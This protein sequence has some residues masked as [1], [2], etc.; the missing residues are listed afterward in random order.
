MIPIH[1]AELAY[2]LITST[3]TTWIYIICHN[4]HD[5]DGLYQPPKGTLYSNMVMNNATTIARI[6]TSYGMWLLN[7][8]IPV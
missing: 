7:V 1:F 2:R 8:V 4:M 6:H 5:A 3:A